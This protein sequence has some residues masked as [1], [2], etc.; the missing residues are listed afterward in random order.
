M[1]ARLPSMR[2]GASVKDVA[3]AAGV[4]LGTVSNVLNRPDRVRPATREKVER[5]MVELG[6]VRNEVGPPAPGRHQPHAGLRDA[7][8]A[9][10]R[11]S[12][13]SRRASRTRPRA[14]G[15]SLFIC[16]SAGSRRARAGPPRAPAAAAGA[17]DPDHPGRPGGRD[18]G[19]HRAARHSRRDRRPHPREPGSSARSPSTTCSAAGSRSS[20]SSTAVTPGSRS[21][22][23]R[24][25]WVRS[26]TAGPARRPPGT[27]QASRPTSSS[28]LGTDELTVAAGRE[29]GERLLG[30][31]ARRRPT[32]A[33]CANDLIALGL[34]Q[35]CIRAGAPGARGPRDRRVRRHRVRR[36]GRRT[37]DLGATAAPG[38]RQHGSARWSPT[39]RSRGT[40]TEQVVFVPELVARASTL[41]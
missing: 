9:A 34:L 19:R 18:P 28:L 25:G 6:F 4:S 39:S 27:M 22:A 1:T 3:A 23:A 24:R 10:T 15:L 2:R 36:R 31:P 30:L 21:S 17:G 29:A 8:R 12:P 20:T 14:S 35:Q 7:R 26:R 40:C 5:A 16:N 37:A 13:T 38:A 32:A 33:F 41:G 11:S